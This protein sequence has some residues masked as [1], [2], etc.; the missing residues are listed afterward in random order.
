MVRVHLCSDGANSSRWVLTDGSLVI[1]TSHLT[2]EDKRAVVKVKG[3]VE[4]YFLPQL[5]LEKKELRSETDK[6]SRSK[7][8]SDKAFEDVGQNLGLNDPMA[9]MESSDDEEPLTTLQDK[10]PRKAFI[11]P[12]VLC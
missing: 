6:T 7:S 2:T 9:L 12:T 11:F 3:G 5:T 4:F 10:D 1:V 8:C